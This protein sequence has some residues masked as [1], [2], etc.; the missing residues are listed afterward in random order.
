MLERMFYHSVHNNYS[1]RAVFQILREYDIKI[2]L[3]EVKFS[4]IKDIFYHLDL[5]KILS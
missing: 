1:I 3:A 5:N 2:T 4:S